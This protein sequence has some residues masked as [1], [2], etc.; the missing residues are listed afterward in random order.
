MLAASRNEAQADWYVL[1]H[2]LISGRADTFGAKICLNPPV[3][4]LQ[5]VEPGSIARGLIIER[6]IEDSWVYI[7]Y[8]I[9]V[10][11]LNSCSSYRQ[12]SAWT[13]IRP[14]NCL[15]LD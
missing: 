4:P 12:T 6:E 13:L 15:S 14:F 8:L 1:G 3:I 2:I 7:Y 9:A 10:G 5:Y 11:V